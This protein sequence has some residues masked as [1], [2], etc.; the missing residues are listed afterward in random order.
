[1]PY[2]NDDLSSIY[3][4]AQLAA[5]VESV[6]EAI[7]STSSNGRVIGWN[8]QAERIFGY[9]AEEMIGKSL[10]ML[11]PSDSFEEVDVL[12]WANRGSEPIHH[13]QTKRARK[14]GRIIEVLLTAIPVRDGNGRLLGVV[15]IARDVG[16]RQR[17]EQAERDRL[18]LAAVSSSVDDAIIGMDLNGTITNWNAAA[19]KLF[20][21][22]PAE[23]V[24]KSMSILIPTDHPD[25]ESQ[26]L[27]R[28]RRGESIDH[29]DTQRVRKDGRIIEVSLA[30]SAI[31]NPTGRIIG[32]CKVLQDIS[33]RK[34]YDEAERE[35][36][37]L[38]S[39]VSSADDAII[40]TDLDGVVT[41]W[42]VAAERLFGYTAE[43][44]FG[45][46]ILLFIPPDHAIEEP[47][48]LERIRRGERI[49]HYETKRVRKDGRTVD[50]SLT[51]SPIKDRMGRVIGASKI[52]RDIT[53]RRRWEKA[54]QAQSFLG[55]LVDS[56]E[57]AIISKN[58]EGIV[59]T[60]NPAAEKLFGYT[61]EEM[62]GKSIT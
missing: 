2:E 52:V 46:P 32:A 27:E 48:I 47:L 36:L 8:R 44:M 10:S 21:Y 12:E 39:I 37:F 3:A 15:R 4:Q 6:D 30:I 9:R 1:M 31:K 25:E 18:F 55:A 38:A 41:S 22:L 57:D 40:S 61:A 49:E 51:V 14:D 58:L 26:I 35:K 28:L 11:N 24:G 42:N 19:E 50:V 34:R 17:I 16:E 53:E 23:I 54:E 33:E 20:G 56:A 5:I 45:K 43:Y 60:W 59:T 13:Y 7:I 62:I 29:Y